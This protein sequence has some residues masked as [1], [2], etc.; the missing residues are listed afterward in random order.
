MKSTQVDNN[1]AKLCSKLR[2]GGGEASADWK[3]L[4]C[5]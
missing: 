3:T 2:L 1:L 5:N 4:C